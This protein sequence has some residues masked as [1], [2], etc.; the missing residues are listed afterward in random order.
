MIDEVIVGKNVLEI[1][2]PSDLLHNWYPKMLTVSFLNLPESM[3]LHHQG[4]N[5]PNTRTVYHGDASNAKP[6]IQNRILRRFNGLISSHTLEHFANPIKALCA[7]STSLVDG[8]GIITIVPN[9]HECWDRVREDTTFEHMVEDFKNDTPNTDMTHLEESS[10]MLETRPTYYQDVGKTNATQVIHHHVFSLS[11]LQMCHEM[12]GF[13][14]LGC[15][16]AEND[17][18]QMIYVGIAT[19][20]RIV[21]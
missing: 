12:A 21:N 11:T 7:W 18:L 16:I 19:G 14:T 4:R 1:G 5:P 9:K 6:F 13:S 8:G 3:A 15:F 20:H 10:C 2:G 17:K